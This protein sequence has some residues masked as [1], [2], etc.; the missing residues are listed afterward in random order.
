MKDPQHSKMRASSKVVVGFVV[1]YECMMVVC[2]SCNSTKHIE[3]VCS[4]LM[5]RADVDAP[6]AHG[7]HAAQSMQQRQVW[8]LPSV[9]GECH[10]VF[11]CQTQP[12]PPLLMRHEHSVHPAAFFKRW[13]S[14]AC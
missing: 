14:G 3:V 9:A 12:R 13:L 10:Q 1:G 11:A 5:I 7:R 6:L 4:S 2:V 8:A